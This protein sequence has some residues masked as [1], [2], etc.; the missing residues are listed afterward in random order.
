MARRHRRVPDAAA[1]RVN[2]G[3]AIREAAVGGR[4]DVPWRLARIF[5]LARVL[6]CMS[7]EP[8]YLPHPACRHIVSLES[9]HSVRVSACTAFGPFMFMSVP[10]VRSGVNP[11]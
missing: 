11:L 3:R 1:A 5:S 6:S 10:K 2:G 8:S 7:R 4:G 9:T